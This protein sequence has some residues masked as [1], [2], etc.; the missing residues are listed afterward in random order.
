M[1][2]RATRSLSIAAALV[3]LG[4][5]TS[6]VPRAARAQD[7]PYVGEIR[8][9][10][11]NFC[12]VGWQPAEGQRLPI[13]DNDTLFNLYGT[14]FGGDGI[15]T[16]ALPD[17]RGRVP[18]GTGQ[19]AGLGSRTLGEQGGVEQ[20]TLT[21]SQLPPH[22]HAAQ[23]SS[24]TS[25]ATTPDATLRSAKSR[26]KIYR[27]GSAANETPAADAIG[28]SGGGQPHENMSPF[29]SMTWCVSLFGVF[30]SQ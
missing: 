9:L 22:T 15:T 2:R 16:F 24:Q 26:T 30:P 8:L 25:N 12:P 13:A 27:S 3:L 17:L 20:V 21:T 28:A 14:T 1:R 23:G 10:A 11:F 7:S 18:I 29:T 5:A 19:G 4:A 6:L